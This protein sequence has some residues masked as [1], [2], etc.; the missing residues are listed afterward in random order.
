MSS[1]PAARRFALIRKR[2]SV[3][4]SRFRVSENGP[5]LRAIQWKTASGSALIAFGLCPCSKELPLH[6][7]AA[8]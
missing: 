6:D 5:G 3:T 7:P 1:A 8:G 4:G 2:L